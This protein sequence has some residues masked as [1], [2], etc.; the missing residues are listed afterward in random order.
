MFHRNHVI[1]LQR[2]LPPRTEKSLYSVAI[3]V[4]LHLRLLLDECFLCQIGTLSVAF[5][6]SLQVQMLG[7]RMRSGTP[8][9]TLHGT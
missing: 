1:P 9:S 2:T 8:T 7:E 3:L 6:R 4:S 5:Q